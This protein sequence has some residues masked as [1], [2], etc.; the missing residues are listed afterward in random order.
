MTLTPLRM[1]CA[2]KGFAFA[3]VIVSTMTPAA[4]LY[5]TLVQCRGGDAWY[6]AAGCLFIAGMQGIVTLMSLKR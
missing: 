1:K 6:V 2:L 5:A 3:V 4:L